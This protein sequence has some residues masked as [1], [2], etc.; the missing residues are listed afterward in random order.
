M[1]S[2]LVLRYVD[3]PCAGFGGRLDVPTLHFLF[4]KQHIIHIAWA[5]SRE[6]KL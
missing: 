2:N 6:E 5:G 3:V 1:L 4:T